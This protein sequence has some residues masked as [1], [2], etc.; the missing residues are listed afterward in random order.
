MGHEKKILVLIPARMASSRFP[1]KIIAPLN[2]L[3]EV[4]VERVYRN[5]EKMS[6]A[7]VQVVTDSEEV[8]ALL[9]SKGISVVRVDDEVE[10]GSERLYLAWKRYF[11]ETSHEFIINVQGD[12]PFIKA[13]ELEHLVEFHRKSTFAITTFV[14]PHSNTEGPFFLNPNR[15]KVAYTRQTGSCHYFSRSP[16][17]FFRD[18]QQGGE[19]FQHV[20]VYSFRPKALENFFSLEASSLEKSEKLEQLR[21]IENGMEIGAIEVKDLP[22]GVDTPEDLEEVK[23]LINKD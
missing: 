20:G 13:C 9:V 3:G 4:L 14:Y 12:E 6:S 7:E 2:S 21:A 8:E 10:S 19:W 11:S 22:I 5:C 16:I 17:P 15:V 23:K 18:G 1:R